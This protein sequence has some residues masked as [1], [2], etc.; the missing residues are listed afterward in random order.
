MSDIARVSDRSA[1]NL[2]FLE[3]LLYDFVSLIVGTKTIAVMP[4]NLSIVAETF[5]VMF[6]HL[7]LR[8]SHALATASK[9]DI[10]AVIVPLS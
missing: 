2:L 7:P 6:K 5:E 9:S 4:L 1:Y 10:Y 8:K 3:D